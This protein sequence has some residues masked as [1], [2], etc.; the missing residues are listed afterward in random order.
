MK[1]D[2]KRTSGAIGVFSKDQL[3]R[4]SAYVQ[5]VLSAMIRHVSPE[6]YS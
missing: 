2:V 1:F 3:D 4:K 6:W 5:I